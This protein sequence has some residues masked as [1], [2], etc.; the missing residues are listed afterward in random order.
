MLLTR[1]ALDK[2]TFP[3]VWTNSFCGHPTPDESVND[4]VM[5]RGRQE[6]GLDIAEL[7]CVLPEFRYRA[8]ASDGVVENEV[9][10]VFCGRAVGTVDADPAE[11]MDSAWV[12]WDQLRAVAQWGWAISPWAVEQVPLLEAAGAGRHG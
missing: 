7:R 4:A 3:G 6:L 8:V 2:R 12:P 11:I 5:R 1:R 9:C 10:P